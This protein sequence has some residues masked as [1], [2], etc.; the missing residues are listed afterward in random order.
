MSILQCASTDKLMQR[1]R[2]V[3]E[4]CEEHNGGR[5]GALAYVRD[6]SGEKRKRIAA[7]YQ[8]PLKRSVCEGPRVFMQ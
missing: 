1:A 3:V 6:R 5:L 4:E 2:V 8:R 7:G